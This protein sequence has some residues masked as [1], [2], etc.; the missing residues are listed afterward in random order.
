MHIPILFHLITLLEVISLLANLLMEEIIISCNLHIQLMEIK[1][2]NRIQDDRKVVLLITIWTHWPVHGFA[3]RIFHATATQGYI[4]IYSSLRY[5][6]I[7]DHISYLLFLMPSTSNPR[8]LPSYKVRWDS[9]TSTATMNK[10]QRGSEH[11]VMLMR[12]DSGLGRM[13]K[14]FVIDKN[15]SCSIVFPVPSNME[16]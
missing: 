14:R 15:A 11:Q 6:R 12:N 1:E 13:R 3:Q 2:S 5:R 4:A 8:P 9:L 16:E 10:N 7:A